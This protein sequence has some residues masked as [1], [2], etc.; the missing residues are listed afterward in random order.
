M[1]IV[2]K[3]QIILAASKEGVVIGIFSKI[4]FAASKQINQ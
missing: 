3:I 1:D 4:N 2:T